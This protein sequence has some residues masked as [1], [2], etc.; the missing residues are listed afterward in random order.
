MNIQLDR[1]K[2]TDRQLPTID[3]FFSRENQ[4]R[5]PTAGADG[6]SFPPQPTLKRFA[7]V[8]ST[9]MRGT[10]STGGQHFDMSQ[11]PDLTIV[12]PS[13]SHRKRATAAERYAQLKQDIVASGVPLLDDEDL[14]AEICERKGVK[15]E[16]KS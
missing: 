1:A 2:L 16:P 10:V 3:L 11:F 6:V 14:R 15:A 12:L 9:I 8:T 4:Y 5:E 13:A 7:I